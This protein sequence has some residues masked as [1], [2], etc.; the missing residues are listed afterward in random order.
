[1]HKIQPGDA[2]QGIGR[3][4]VQILFGTRQVAARGQPQE[5]HAAWVWCVCVLLYQLELTVRF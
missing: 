1:M 5:G 3:L 4:C 2:A